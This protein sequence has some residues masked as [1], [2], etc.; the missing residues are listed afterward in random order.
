MVWFG[1][2]WRTDRTEQTQAGCSCA[3][4]PTLP[5]TRLSRAALSITH[6]THNSHLVG[7]ETTIRQTASPPIL[8]R[9]A[10]GPTNCSGLAVPSP[11]KFSYN[12]EG[13][14]L[15][16]SI[17]SLSTTATVAAST[18][19]SAATPKTEHKQIPIIITVNNNK[20]KNKHRTQNIEHTQFNVR[21]TSNPSL[22]AVVCSCCL[23][24]AARFPVCASMCEVAHH[25]H[26]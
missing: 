1:L 6:S 13:L 11:Q 25:Q 24:V 17:H 15:S 8:H 19:Q 5:R 4:R 2:V 18:L 26:T 14:L 16:L 23:Y 20:N 12:K 21:V 9:T 22:L 3:T 10:A 7:D